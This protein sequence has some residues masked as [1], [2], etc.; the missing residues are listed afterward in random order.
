MAFGIKVTDLDGERIG[1]GRGVGRYFASWLSCVILMIGLLMAAFTKKRQ[2][3]HDMVSGTLVVNGK[4]DPAD[5]AAGGGTMPITGGVMAMIVFLVVV[6][7]FGGILAAVAIPAYSDYTTRAKV[8][9]VLA[10]ASP[11]KSEIEQAFSAK[12]Q[13][14]IGAATVSNRDA[15]A[16]TVTPKGEIL[17]KLM[18]SLGNGG[19]IVHT[20]T[21]DS[22]G[23]VAWRCSSADVPKKYL[24]VACRS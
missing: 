9:G 21:F 8:A 17:I 3:L 18:P 22:A 4:A 19:T 6:P 11:L 24:P 5:L 16:V 13:F 10:A 15:Q 20:P 12:R 2:A 23:T 7:F 14:A 1:I